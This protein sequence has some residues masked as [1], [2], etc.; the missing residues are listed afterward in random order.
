MMKYILCLF[1]LYFYPL[2]SYSNNSFKI[3]DWFKPSAYRVVGL[4]PNGNRVLWLE[5]DIGDNDRQYLLIQTMT[6]NKNLRISIPAGEHYHFATFLDREQLILQ[7]N[8]NER[9]KVYRINL[10]TQKTKL[11]LN[12][13]MPLELVSIESSGN[14]VWFHFD[15]QL[16]QFD[17]QKGQ[18]VSHVELPSSISATQMTPQ[19]KPCLAWSVEGEAFAWRDDRW[20]S[21]KLP[22][23]TQ[24]L[25][26]N[27]KCSKFWLL[28]RHNTDKVHLL[29]MDFQSKLKPLYQRNDFD[30]KSLLLSKDRSQLLAVHYDGVYF[31]TVTFDKRVA[32]LTNFIAKEND[33]WH[34][35]GVSHDLNFWL[36]KR[37]RP[38]LPEETLW[39]DLKSKRMVKLDSRLKGYDDHSWANTTAITTPFENGHLISYL[40]MPRQKKVQPALII[41]LHGG[42]FSVRDVWHFDPEAQWFA[43]RGIATLS[44]NYRGSAGFGADF[45]VQAFT[46]LRNSVEEDIESVLTHVFSSFSINKNSLCL[47]GASFGGFAVLSELIVNSSD[48]R[49][50]ILLSSVT[51]LNLVYQK[52]QSDDERSLFVTRFGNPED[53]Q[54]RENNNLL[55]FVDDLETPLFVVYGKK[56]TVVDPNNSQQLISLLNKKKKPFQ[57][58]VFEEADHEMIEFAQRKEMYQQIET[59]LRNQNMLISN[60]LSD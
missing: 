31:S 20:I 30:L 55:S 57:E 43:E 15:K 18:I 60:N 17:L 1:I 46:Q 24:Q 3:D 23:S 49:C 29:E 27:D 16:H 37:Q 5:N 53:I 45:Q 12:Q 9:A 42:P 58:L 59:F 40:T 13:S 39:I 4:S 22:K 2:N 11:M 6:N 38:N 33:R 26:A 54:W 28:A 21:L 25:E 7:T 41:K 35:I 36:I 19:G 52:L 34:S 56:D 32:Q 47:Y 44:I 51:D 10:S 50:G 48:Y 8:E 14:A